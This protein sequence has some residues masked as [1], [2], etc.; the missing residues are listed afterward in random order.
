MPRH[1][2]QVTSFSGNL[3]AALLHK[4]SSLCEYDIVWDSDHLSHEVDEN[5]KPL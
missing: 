4:E 1:Q 5:G 2:G 3:I